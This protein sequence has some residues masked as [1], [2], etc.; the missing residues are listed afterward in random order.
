MLFTIFFDIEADI[1]TYLWFAIYFGVALV[2]YLFGTGQ[3]FGKESKIKIIKNTKEL[4]PTTLEVPNRFY[5][6]LREFVNVFLLFSVLAF[7]YSSLASFQQ[8]VKM[9]ERFMI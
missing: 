1:K 6:V 2:P 7:I 8:T 3:S 5:L 4:V 9:E